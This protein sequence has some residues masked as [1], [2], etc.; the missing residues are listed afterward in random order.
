[1]PS[2]HKNKGSEARR[3]SS[4]R[5]ETIKYYR[6]TSGWVSLELR[7]LWEYR[8]V[9][10]FL[11]WRDIKVRYKQTVLGALW[12]IL[13]PLMVMVIF[14]IIFGRLLKAPS[15]DIPYPLFAYS[16]LTIWTFFANGV[17][18]A[19]NS[20]VMEGNM[21]K[22][23]YFPRM[24]IPIAS[25]AA[26]MVDFCIAFV[27]LVGMMIYYGKTPS[28]AI[29]TLPLFIILAVSA[30]LGLGLW[31]GALN[32]MFRDV[33]YLIPFL[34][35]VLL[36]ASPVAYSSNLIADKGAW[37]ILYGLNPM[38]GVIIGFRWALLK[39]PIE[40]PVILATSAAVTI[41]LLITGSFFF[42]RVEKNFADVV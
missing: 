9:I 3:K 21:I 39:T 41:S 8:E 31:L 32:V 36:Y 13:Q 12:A 4:E 42:K 26:G 16:A 30:T 18:L 28:M 37:N 5:K 22:K 27:I 6:P 24:S 14:T 1:M 11:T 19:S 34:L 23:V 7:E 17:T 33:R 15:D 10:Y 35:Q 40:Q 2:R 20:M 38:A 29:L 25:V